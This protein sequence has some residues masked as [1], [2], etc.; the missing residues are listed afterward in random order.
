MSPSAG[1]PEIALAAGDCMSGFDLRDAAPVTAHRGVP[2]ARTLRRRRLLGS[3]ETA[4]DAEAAGGRSSPQGAIPLSRG[5]RG[6][7]YGAFRFGH[8]AYHPFDTRQA[9]ARLSAMGGSMLGSSQGLALAC[10]P[11]SQSL[12]AC[13]AHLE[14]RKGRTSCRQARCGGSRR[15]RG[16]S[17]P[18]SGRPGTHSVGLVVDL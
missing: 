7:R 9:R 10:G 4:G 6:S 14:P 13:R 3:C 15:R 17:S 12:A 8:P 2:H 11:E 16:R 1:N 5:T 18:G